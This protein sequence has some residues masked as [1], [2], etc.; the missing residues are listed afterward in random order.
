[1]RAV[2]PQLSRA[3][4]GR[5]VR[6]RDDGG[7]RRTTERQ[8]PRCFDDRYLKRFGFR[9]FCTASAAPVTAA[10][11]TTTAPTRFAAFATLAILRLRCCFFTRAETA[12]VALLVSAD[13]RFVAA[14][15]TRP[16]FFAALR[17]RVFIR[18]SGWLPVMVT[19][20]LNV[21]PDLQ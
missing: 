3:A 16:A 2:S 17:T 18:T 10:A 21:T 12:F 11:V 13:A 14:D 4:A 8:L 5:H 1:M 6:S 20:F 7:R 9:A 15:A 19:R